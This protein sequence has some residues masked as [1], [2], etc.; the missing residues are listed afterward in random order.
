[1]FEDW[2]LFKVELTQNFRPTNPITNTESAI[3][4]LSL[5]ED[6]KVIKYFIEFTILEVKC[7]PLWYINPA[8]FILYLTLLKPSTSTIGCILVSNDYSIFTTSTGGDI[9]KCPL[10]YSGS[11]NCPYVGNNFVVDVV[12]RSRLW[13]RTRVNVLSWVGDGNR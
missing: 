12:V 4:K 2:A 1:M 10:S 6:G 7:F 11:K 3:K 13:R 8:N 9:L 5:A